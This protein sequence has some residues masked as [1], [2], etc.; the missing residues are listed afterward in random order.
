MSDR[1]ALSRFQSGSSS[2]VDG[3]VEVL[4]GIAHPGGQ[5]IIVRGQCVQERIVGVF[6]V[7]NLHRKPELTKGGPSWCRM[8]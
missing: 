4:R 1:N 2:R 7:I 8:R 3:L 5:P 6:A